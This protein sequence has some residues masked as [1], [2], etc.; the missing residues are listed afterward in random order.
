MARDARDIPDVRV[1][2]VGPFSGPRAA[3]GRLLTSAAARHPGVRWEFHDDRGDQVVAARIAAGVVTGGYAAVIGH[4]NSLGARASLPLYASAGLPVV[5]PLSTRPGL[6]DGYRNAVQWCPDDLDQ[7]AAL[8]L[9]AATHGVRRLGVRHDGT[10]YGRGMAELFGGEADGDGLVVCGTHHGSAARAR[11]LR[12]DGFAGPLYFTD[13]CAVDEF[14]EL[15]GDAADGARVVRLT[16]GA[17]SFVDSA[18]DALVRFLDQPDIAARVRAAKPVAGWEVVPVERVPHHDVVVV[19]AGIVGAAT[20]A[21]LVQAGVSVAVCAPADDAESATRYS[22][23]LVR[24]YEHDGE[25]RRL[26]IRSHH[27][28]WRDSPRFHRTGSLVLLGPDQLAEAA[29]GVHELLAAGIEAELLDADELRRDFDLDAAGAVWEPGGGYASPPVVARDLLDGVARYDTRVLRTEPDPRGTRLVTTTGPV[30]AG[31]VVVAAGA[32]TPALA[33]V[34]P[35]RLKRIR[36][37]FFDRG[38]RD[39]PTVYDQRTGMW[40]R[41]VHDGPYAGG[42]LAGR[43]VEEWD[44]GP[45]GGDDLTDDQVAYVREGLRRLWPWLGEAAYLGGRYGADLF[46]AA[47]VIGPVGDVVVAACFAG[48]GFKTAPAAGEQ[49]AFAAVKARPAALTG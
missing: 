39:V 19:G 35:A 20:A 48:G 4:F 12:A 15:A 27:L 10:D 46:G 2:V 30:T 34:G 42:F 37:A 9:V 40:G 1:A 44:V 16:G 29:A 38:G 36:Y 5:L 23:G 17:Q 41:P 21:A 6:A 24:A 3:W 13:D 33:D 28:L 45:G 7:V 31:V 25:Q 26:A 22:G 43:P 47:P 14:A 8:R 32:G 11:E 18:F 49:A